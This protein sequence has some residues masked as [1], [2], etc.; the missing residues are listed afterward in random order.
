MSKQPDPPSVASRR[1]FTQALMPSSTGEDSTFPL[2]VSIPVLMPVIDVG[3][4]VNQHFLRD[5]STRERHEFPLGINL[6]KQSTG[7]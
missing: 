1:G 2:V 7:R 6:C 3:A 4:G 5:L